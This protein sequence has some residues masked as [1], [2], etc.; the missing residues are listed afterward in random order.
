MAHTQAPIK[1]IRLLR[2]K[3]TNKQ[4]V[5]ILCWWWWWCCCR[6][7]RHKWVSVKSGAIGRVRALLRSFLPR[8]FNDSFT[9]S[10]GLPC[11]FM[12]NDIVKSHRMNARCSS[13]SLLNF[14]LSFDDFKYIFTS[15]NP[16]VFHTVLSASR[17][18]RHSCTFYSHRSVLFSFVR[19]SPLM[20]RLT[21]LEWMRNCCVSC[22]C[23]FIDGTRMNLCT[24]KLYHDIV[25]IAD[26]VGDT[27]ILLY[28]ISLWNRESTIASVVCRKFYI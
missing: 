20:L 1:A 3:Q 16:I 15:I 10:N 27:V 11:V 7:C 23:C 9:G 26:D 6:R 5:H 12:L 13:S 28:F 4:C 18:N 19:T 22:V 8:V 14:C 24:E 17:S 21:K 2:D 25:D